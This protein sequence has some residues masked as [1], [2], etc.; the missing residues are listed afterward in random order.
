MVSDPGS[1]RGPLGERPLGDVP[2]GIEVERIEASLRER[3]FGEKATT[4]VGR[5]TLLE[6]LGRGGMGSV[7][8]AYDPELDR[9]VAIKVVRPDRASDRSREQLQSEAKILARMSHPNVVTIYE[10][11]EAGSGDVFIAMEYLGGGTLAQWMR[12]HAGEPSRWASVVE[13]FDDVGRGLAAAHAEGVVHRDF[14]PANVLL[15]TD[16]RPRVVDFGLAHAAEPEPTSIVGTPAYMAPEQRDGGVVD[17]RTDQFSFCVA[18]HEALFGTRPDTARG[19]PLPEGASSIPRRVAAALRRGLSPAPS[20]RFPTL[21]A[22]LAEIRPRRSRSSAA[23]AI[24]AVALVATGFAVLAPG[25]PAGPADPCAEPRATVAAAWPGGS[26]LAARLHGAGASYRDQVQREL[27][28]VCSG[29]IDPVAVACLRRSALQ[30]AAV[31]DAVQ[32]ATTPSDTALEAIKRLPAPVECSSPA[33]LASEPPMPTDPE[34]RADRQDQRDRLA[35]AMVDAMLGHE[36]EARAGLEDSLGSEDLVVRAEAERVAGSIDARA[37]RGE[38]AD[39]HL[40]AAALAAEA[41]GYDWL[42]VTA[43]IEGA[44]VVAQYLGRFD[45]AQARLQVAQAGVTRLGEPAILREKL[46]ATEGLVAFA[47]GRPADAIETLTEAIEAIEAR[48]GTEAFALVQPCNVLAASYAAQGQFERAYATFERVGGLI[49]T[50]YGDEH[51]LYARLSINLGAAARDAGKLD[52]AAEHTQVAIELLRR[53][54]GPSHPS[55]VQAL[56]NLADI[57]GRRGRHPRA[58]TLATEALQAAELAHGKDSPELR[59]ALATLA[60]AQSDTGEHEA[61]LASV[62]RAHEL[63]VN[64]WGD[65]ALQL[66]EII[67]V[68]ADVLGRLGR[69]DERRGTLERARSIA[70]RHEAELPVELRRALAQ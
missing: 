23:V 25:D 1:H 59:W 47:A 68:E 56:H 12:E 13:M 15:G 17:A 48:R 62:A 30:L 10:V 53:R 19:G 50:H 4:K 60:V 52:R 39:Q 66:L 65:D 38:S 18:L 3:L 26:E 34:Q 58:L 31:A 22:L 63:V 33:R 69:D 27:D 21:A 14:K 44:A 40:R 46:Q 28:A 20:D 67:E 11:G 54:L 7:Y 6:P 45:D 49:E 43:T 57:E 64:A 16:G 36:A 51:P 70:S 9:K 24:A 41:A 8:A 55:L 61:A 32:G 35:A 5:F 2:G 37:I 29:S 42:K